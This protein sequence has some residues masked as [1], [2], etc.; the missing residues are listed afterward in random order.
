MVFGCD[1][2]AMPYCFDYKQNGI[3]ISKTELFSSF[4]QSHSRMR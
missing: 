2:F 3:F 1:H 4:D